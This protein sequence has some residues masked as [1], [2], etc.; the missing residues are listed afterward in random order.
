MSGGGAAGGVAARVVARPPVGALG[1]G[2]GGGAGR[3][4]GGGGGGRG[5]RRGRGGRGG[6]GGPGDH[7]PAGAERPR[8][9]DSENPPAAPRHVPRPDPAASE[10][11]DDGLLPRQD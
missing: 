2:G 1:G 10:S 5:G 8:Q 11:P 9:H 7:P 6:R 3:G 4:G